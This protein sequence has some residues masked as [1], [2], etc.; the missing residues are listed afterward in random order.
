M[1][2]ERIGLI[3]NNGI[4][5]STLLRILLGELHPDSGSVKLGTNLEIGYLDQIRRKL[6][7][8]KSV[9]HNVG[10]GRDYITLYGKQRHVIGYLKDFLFSHKRAVTPVKAL[11]GGECNRVLLAK[12]FTKPVNL[13]VLDEPTNDL[14]V[15]MLEVLEERLI[16]YQGTLII[17]SHDREFLDHV[18][19]RV[20]VFEGGGNIQSYIGGYSDWVQRGKILAVTDNPHQSGNL[21]ASPDVQNKT[22]KPKKLSYKLQRELDALPEQIEA[23]E[24]TISKLEAIT[25]ASDFFNQ[26]Y[27]ETHTVLEELKAT[28]A[29]LDASIE[30]W[31]ELE[32]MQN[33]NKAHD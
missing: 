23:L 5:K 15:E 6:E 29:T 11:S 13:L 26:P 22:T 16:H 3:G 25:N 20:L 24:N 19:D 8:E 21:E 10:D 17:V 1:R 12:L 30:R 33:T 31:S 14:D 9:A 32:G 2:G 27:E 28:Q 18:V 4:G 7:M